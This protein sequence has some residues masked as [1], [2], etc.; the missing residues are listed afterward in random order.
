MV[1]LRTEKNIDGVLLNPLK[2]IDTVGGSVLHGM[3]KGDLG[4]SSFGEAYFSLVKK[5][6]IKGWKRHRKMTLNLIVPVGIIRF[7]IYDDRLQSSTFKKYQEFILS[8]SNYH[9]L[10]VPPMVWMAFQGKGDDINM[11]LNIANLQHDPKEADQ[12]SVD[13]ISFNW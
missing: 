12:K 2:V 7:V 5:H 9:R 8:K 13:E 6:A 4:Y 1:A 11:L 3:K 10:T